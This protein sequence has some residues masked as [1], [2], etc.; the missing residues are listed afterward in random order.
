MERKVFMKTKKALTIEI[1][2]RFRD[3][4]AMNHVNNAVFFTY[5]EEGR[6]VFLCGDNNFDGF[7]F[8]LGSISCKYLKPIKV[9][10]KLNLDLW[11]KKIGVKSFDFGY[12]LFDRSDTSIIFATGESTQVC[13]DYNRNASINISDAQRKELE[14]FLTAS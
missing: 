9:D 10:T 14:K 11:V 12:R 2:V 13:Y 7:F 3:I 5:F 8:I 6:K 1:S 4:D